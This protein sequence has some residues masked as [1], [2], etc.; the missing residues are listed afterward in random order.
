MINLAEIRVGDKVHYQP[1]YY[2]FEKWDNGIVKEI[3]EER[4]F[5]VFNCAG[6][7]ENYKNYTG[8]LTKIKDLYKGWRH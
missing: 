5:V 2:D 3:T 4:V 6:D 8:C 7:W 1:S